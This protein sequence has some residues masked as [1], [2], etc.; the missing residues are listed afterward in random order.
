M[1]GLSGMSAPDRDFVSSDFNLVRFLN[2][3]MIQKNLFVMIRQRLLDIVYYR[4]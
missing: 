1:K 2:N 3:C 4:L